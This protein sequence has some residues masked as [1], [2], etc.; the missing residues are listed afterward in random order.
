MSRV[1]RRTRQAISA[2]RG[3]PSG[4]PLCSGPSAGSLGSLA[5]SLLSAK[6]GH[7]GTAV[8]NPARPCLPV[9]VGTTGRQAA[10]GRRQGK[11]GWRELGGLIPTMPHAVQ[12]MGCLGAVATSKPSQTTWGCR[13]RPPRASHLPQAP[14]PSAP[15]PQ[16]GQGQE[17]SGL[18]GG[19]EG[20]PWWS[21]G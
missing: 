7:E 5:C 10:P 1:K 12:I 14:G 13:A 18:N 11:R 19:I 16:W 17:D 8:N 4:L 21:N 15:P 20:L 2:L 3:P 6:C 9:L